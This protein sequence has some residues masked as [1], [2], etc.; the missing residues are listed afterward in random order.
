MTI[1]Y[2]PGRTGGLTDADLTEALAAIY[3]PG[4]APAAKE[5]A[6]NSGYSRHRPGDQLSGTTRRAA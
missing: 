2:D 5:I 3:G 6:F 1:T 4:S